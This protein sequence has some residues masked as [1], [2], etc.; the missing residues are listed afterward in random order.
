MKNRAFFFLTSLEKE[1]S[2][3]G[4]SDNKGKMYLSH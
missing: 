4:I 1:Y 3:V 2:L